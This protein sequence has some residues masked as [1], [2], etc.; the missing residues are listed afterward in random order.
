MLAT[1]PQSAWFSRTPAAVDQKQTARLADERRRRA[2][3]DAVRLVRQLARLQ[4]LTQL[5]EPG[6]FVGAL[7]RAFEDAG[8][9]IVDV[10]QLA[11]DADALAD[12]MADEKCGNEQQAD[13]GGA[14]DGEVAHRVARALLRARRSLGQQHAFVTL[15][16]DQRVADGVHLA[17][18]FAGCHDL[19]G[20]RGTRISSASR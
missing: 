1:S 11:S 12:V 8:E 18:A 14:G 10:G 3:D 16:L 7:L 17:V 19:G 20:L 4:Q 6:D 9:A 15:G 13:G 2:F 5:G